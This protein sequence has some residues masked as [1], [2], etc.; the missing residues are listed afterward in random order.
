MN[1]QHQVSTGQLDRLAFVPDPI[2]SIYFPP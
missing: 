1:I 2:I